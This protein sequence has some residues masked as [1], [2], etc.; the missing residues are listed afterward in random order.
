MELINYRHF[1][2]VKYFEGEKGYI[3]EHIERPEDFDEFLPVVP[4][5]WTHG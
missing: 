3:N 1:C 2:Y 5:G 4:V